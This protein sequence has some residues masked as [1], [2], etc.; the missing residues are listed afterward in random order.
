MSTTNGSKTI[1][2]AMA[3]FDLTNSSNI[4]LSVA[5]STQGN[6]NAVGDPVPGVDV[7]L[8]QI[9]GGISAPANQTS[10]GSVLTFGHSSYD[11]PK[12]GEVVA[13]MNL[14]AAFRPTFVSGAPAC[15]TNT[16]TAMTLAGK[17]ENPGSFVGGAGAVSSEVAAIN[18]PILAQISFSTPVIS[19][20]GYV[21]RELANTPGENDTAAHNDLD[22]PMALF[23]I[24]VCPAPSTVGVSAAL[25]FVGTTPSQTT[26]G[27]GNVRALVDFPSGT[28]TRTSTAYVDLL[29]GSTPVFS[30]SSDCTENYPGAPSFDCGNG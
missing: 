17:W 3:A 23:D 15:S 26:S 2:S 24:G 8:E 21:V 9:P 20:A 29:H 5:G 13:T 19:F 18:G 14:Q 4:G 28:T 27:N 12:N 10:S 25:Q 16:P 30:A 1:S 11:A 7:S 22:I 6:L